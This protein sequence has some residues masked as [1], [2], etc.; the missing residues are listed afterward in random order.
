[1]PNVWRDWLARLPLPLLALS[2]AWGVWQF[3][4]LF[5]PWYVAA[6]S[7]IAF[8]SVYLSLAFVPT[9]DRRRAVVIA[10]AAVA[11]SVVYN[12]L[13][14]LFH[15]RPALLV[16][17]PLWADLSLATLHG[18]PL[19]VVAYAVADL[20]LHRVAPVARPVAPV[21][22]LVA[23]PS[24]VVV[25]DDTPSDTRDNDATPRVALKQLAAEAGVSVRTYQRRKKKEP[26]S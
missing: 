14:S 25:V 8:E 23:L 17:R 2:A 9:Q 22:R 15:I 13:S 12:T 6:L 10:I 7:A 26:T 19:A 20:L 5:V 1:M 24:P 11:V 16:A 21:T 3:Q 18:L 4:S